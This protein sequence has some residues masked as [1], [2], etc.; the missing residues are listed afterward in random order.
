[1]VALF[2]F[3]DV[4]YAIAIG[5]EFTIPC[6]VVEG[7]GIH[8][9]EACPIFAVVRNVVQ[10]APITGQRAVWT[11][12]ASAEEVGQLD[13][14][15]ESVAIRIVQVFSVEVEDDAAGGTVFSGIFRDHSF[16]EMRAV[17]KGA[18]EDFVDATL[19]VATVE[20]GFEFSAAGGVFSERRLLVTIPKELDIAGSDTL[21]SGDGHDGFEERFGDCCAAGMIDGDRLTSGIDGE[22]AG[23]RGV[24]ND[25]ACGAAVC[26]GGGEGD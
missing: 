20:C 3:L 21:A 12:V 24:V 11:W 17:D 13:I 10:A 14:V 23:Q 1:M 16:E 22:V 18:V 19:A 15:G 5:I 6:A 8:G 9:V 7:L 25:A 26:F 2:E 4:G